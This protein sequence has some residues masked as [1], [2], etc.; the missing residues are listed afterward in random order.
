ME[1]IK[2]NFEL[3]F[4]KKTSFVLNSLSNIL[5]SLENLF[6]KSIL[7][8]SN[9]SKSLSISILEYLEFEASVSIILVFRFTNE[10][11]LFENK[12][13]ALDSVLKLSNLEEESPGVFDLFCRFKGIIPRKMDMKKNR[14]KMN[15]D[16]ALLECDYKI[17]KLYSNKDFQTY[18]KEFCKALFNQG[19]NFLCI[20]YLEKTIL[21]LD[22]E[23][24]N[25]IKKIP[26]KTDL[27][28]EEIYSEIKLK[29]LGINFPDIKLDP[30]KWEFYAEVFDCSFV[31]VILDEEFLSLVKNGKNFSINEYLICV[32]K[33]EVLKKGRKT[34]DKFYVKKVLK[35]IKKDIQFSSFLD[36]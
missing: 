24:I 5:L 7:I 35:H 27:V 20:K 1:E 30:P 4:D 26:I 32:L 9:A 19:V 17:Y 34:I 31:A 12:I 13:Y 29:I 23:K 11:S 28:K 10:D 14:V 16:G 3:F 6:K 25:V 2:L 15:F 21:I 18:S 22:K 33:Q 36:L 8:T